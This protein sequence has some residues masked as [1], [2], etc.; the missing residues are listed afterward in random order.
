M[1]VR[2]RGVAA[3]NLRATICLALAIDPSRQNLSNVGRPIPI[4]D[5]AAQPL[6][7]LLS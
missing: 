6:R 7:E 3:A 5:R 1:E 4:V 2:G